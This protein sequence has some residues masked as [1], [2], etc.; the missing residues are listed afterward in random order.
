MRHRLAVIGLFA[1]LL[2]A[3]RARATTASNICTANAN[4]C[5]VT[6]DIAVNPGSVLDFGTRALQIRPTGRLR[7]S[8]GV[9]SIIAGSL[10]MEPSALISGA[11]GTTSG[12][13]INVTTSGDIRVEATGS[14]TAR[15]D[16]TANTAP[17]EIELT[18]TGGNI[19]LAGRLVADG[20]GY[21]GAGGAVTA[22]AGGT[23]TLSGDVS[24]R[25]GAPG[26]GGRVVLQAHGP[27]TVS[28]TAVASGGDGGDID[29]VSDTADVMLATG[30][31]LDVRAGGD[32]GDAGDIGIAAQGNV[33]VNGMI[34]GIGAGS[35][36]QGGGFGAEVQLT[37]T[38]GTVSVNG[39]QD[40]HGAAPDGEGGDFDAFGGLDV[41]FGAAARTFLHTGGLDGCGGFFSASAGRN[42]NLGG[43]FG[44]EGGYCGGEVDSDAGQQLTVSADLNTD[45]TGA[46]GIINLDAFR[47]MVGARLRASGTGSFANGGFIGLRAC[48]I[49]Q[50]AGSSSLWQASGPN[51][52]IVTQAS[53]QTTIGGTVRAVGGSIRF[54]YRQT[55]PVI[56]GSASVSP[57]PVIAQNSALPPCTTAA[58]GNGTI[59]VG[60]QCD[61][62]NTVPCDGCTPGCD[63]E[64]CGNGVI[65]CNEECDAGPANG[66]P[67]SQCDAT[68]HAQQAGGVLYLPGGTRGPAACVLEW[69]LVNPGGEITRGFPDP[70]QTCIDGDPSCDADGNDDGGCDFTLSICLNVTDERVPDCDPEATDWVN[71]RRPSPLHAVDANEQAS[72]DALVD[73]LM[74]LGITVKSEDRTLQTGVPAA[75]RDLCTGAIHMRVPHP[76]GT[77]G[78]RILH[79]TGR[80]AGGVR[81]RRNRGT[82]VC[83]PNPSTCGNGVIE[84]TETCDDGNAAACDGCSDRCK[85]ERCGDGIVSCGEQCDDGVAN[86][87]PAS[88]C[89]S[90]CTDAPPA[91]RI[92]ASPGRRDCVHEW[93]I[94][95]GAP[96]VLNNGLP[97]AQQTCVDNDPSCD[98]DPTPGNCRFHLWECMGGA[99]SRIACGA[100]AI[101]GA[102]VLRPNAAAT[103]ADGN[104]RQAL[105]N[106]L[107]L[108]QFPVGPGEFCAGRAD[109]DV[110][111]G[112]RRLVLRA[113]ATTAAGFTDRDTLRLGC[114]PSP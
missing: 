111:A 59:E 78:R 32:F 4:P 106:A 87:T 8:S 99:D 66:V 93:S 92:P 15:I 34:S 18:S 84:V 73:G 62:G 36:Q 94:E 51:G 71:L 46:G 35:D 38:T 26:L 37:A 30:A 102:T 60:E 48:D 114:T 33:T 109:I 45:G 64:V 86:G 47:I 91:L 79:A 5:L 61:D 40:L 65:D 2:A 43:T 74:A 14:G 80:D 96:T 44:L 25:G 90:Y 21:N 16:A 110:P 17:G 29:L 70:T 6:T 12:A 113:G 103:G 23:L 55:A 7:V 13:R 76:D 54:E 63:Q 10:R 41:I 72:A 68:C 89:T 108:L 56:Q 67:G 101:T 97:S 107:S 22:T 49:T 39:T 75:Q 1:S 58:C 81:P 9:L 3:P 24:V 50:S 98:F 112:R 88:D 28:G 77:S 95:H 53:G 104:V 83:A 57:A 69:A 85:I 52:Q 100:E 20:S 19:V 42:A 27:L 105:I 82:L 11:A 31:T